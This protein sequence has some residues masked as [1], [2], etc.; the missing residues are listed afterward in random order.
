M[1]Q[2]RG[3]RMLITG[4]SAGIGEACAKKA[5]QNGIDLVLCARRKERLETLRKEIQEINPVA[6]DLFEVDVRER[7]SVEA[8]LQTLEAQ[9]KMPDILMNNAGLSQG[10]DP[11]DKADIGDWERM[12][13]TN[14]K[15]LLYITRLLLPHLKT[16]SLA[17]IIN[18]GSIAGRQV[19]PGGSVYNATKSAVHALNEAMNIDLLGTPV[20]VSLIAPGA[21]KTEFSEVRFHGDKSRAENVYQGYQPL[22]AADIA[23]AVMYVLGAPPHVNVQEIVIMPTAQRNAYLVDRGY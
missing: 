16:R 8:M 1:E 6:V 2:W 4:A 18:L 17:H 23:D 11:M 14:L 15:G 5:A 12:I 21:V 20:R 19:Y 10:L 3:K 9:E 22:E 13:D 7:R